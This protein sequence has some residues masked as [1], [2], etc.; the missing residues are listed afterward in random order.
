M[1]NFIWT[2]SALKDLE[3]DT[4][5]PLRWYEQW[6]NKSISFPSSEAQ[7]MGNFFEYLCIGANAKGEAVKSLPLTKANEKTAAHKR[8]EMQASRFRDLFDPLHPDFQGFKITDT[9]TLLEGVINGIPAQ[10]TIDIGAINVSNGNPAIIDLKLTADAMNVNSEYSW[11]NHIEQL[12]L[13]Q[14]VLYRELYQQ[15]FGVYP[16]MVL[17]IFEHGTK[18]N[19]RV[20]HLDIQDYRIAWVSDRLLQ[21]KEVTD[22]YDQNGWITHASPQECKRCTLKCDKRQFE[23][24]LFVETHKY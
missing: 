10:G 2:Q 1:D 9:Q 4:T 19:I 13:V 8:I 22:L 17:M 16:E 6:V 7:D 11:G 18:M 3:K 21:A 24:S 14:Q 20:I 15:K 23:S 12:D 5:C